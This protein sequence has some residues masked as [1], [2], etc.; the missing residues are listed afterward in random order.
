MPSDLTGHADNG[1]NKFLVCHQ[2]LSRWQV[3]LEYY[4]YYFCKATAPQLLLQSGWSCAEAAELTILTEKITEYFCF[5]HKQ[6][7]SSHGIS[8]QER[9]SFCAKLQEVRQIRNFA[10]HRTTLHTNTLQKYARAVQEV[11]GLLRR[12]GGEIIQ[13]SCTNRLD[14]FIHTFWELDIKSNDQEQVDLSTNTSTEMVQRVEGL[15][16]RKQKELNIEQAIQKQ[17]LAAQTRASNIS[18]MVEEFQASKRARDT[19]RHR[20]QQQNKDAERRRAERAEKAMREQEEAEHRRAER[21]KKS[22]K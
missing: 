11:L 5:H 8:A 20:N 10:V 17:R 22:R 18:L 6:F 19:R 4:L 3:E 21:A 1:K 13:Q 16:R 7:F 14:H 9:E 2:L 15:P 12:L